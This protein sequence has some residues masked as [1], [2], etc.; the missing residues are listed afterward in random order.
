MSD[1]L[2][3][4]GECQRRYDNMQP[5][6]YYDPK[7]PK[8]DPF[9]PKWVVCRGCGLHVRNL[10]DGNLCEQCDEELSQ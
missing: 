7:P 4:L 6:D 5:P 8:E 1:N 10:N 9:P 2:K 3:A